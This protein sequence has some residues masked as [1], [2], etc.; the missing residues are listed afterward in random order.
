MAESRS[1]PTELAYHVDMTYPSTA[2]S[3]Y[4]RIVAVAGVLTCAC[5]SDNGGTGE[6]TGTGAADSSSTV[7]DPSTGDSSGP[8]DSGSGDPSSTGPSMTTTP[9][10][11]C[12]N[13]VREDPEQ[14]DDGNLRPGDG[15]DVDCTEIV[16]TSLWQDVVGGSASVE[17]AAQAVAFD[18]LGNV[19]AAGWIVDVVGAPD[20]WLRK[21]SPN[22]DVLWTQTF[23]PSGGDAD[24]AFGVA[25]A[26]DDTI[27]VTGTAGV[28]MTTGDIWTA[29]LSADGVAFWEQTV[30]GPLGEHDSGNGVAVDDG[31]NVWVTGFVRTGAGDDD[32]WVG[33][34]DSSGML[35]F[36]EF[37]AG[38]AELEDHGQGIAVDADG[39]AFA[40][41]YVS[42]VEFGGDVWLRKYAP[43]GSVA[44]TTGF[45]SQ[46]HGVDEAYGVAV[47][48]DGSVGVAGFTS[49]TAINAD[50]WLG[51]FANEDGELTWQKKFGGPE[52]LDDAGLAVAADSQGAFVVAGFKG[53]AEVDTDIWVRKWAGDGAVA[54]TQSVVG[55]GGDRDFA[56]GV[57]VDGNDDIA[58]V[59]ELRERANNNGDIW[60]AKLGG[61]P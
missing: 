18:T 41:G 22:G 43:D 14:C 16:D 42:D 45:D 34:Y 6:A 29:R 47:A 8:A 59:G 46:N 39:N 1:G 17:E 48:P 2:P 19:I 49:L 26:Q 36:S 13:G 25:V 61:N 44:W 37:V 54:W 12:G 60:V 5:G 7:V 51:K 35:L 53:I 30:D 24:R 50:V 52:I 57:A 3:S 58:V 23:D 15:C 10:P 11:E 33:E 40:A 31:F 32:I 9:V 56:Y 4:S 20:I 38:P 28:G 55:A 27:A 21:Y